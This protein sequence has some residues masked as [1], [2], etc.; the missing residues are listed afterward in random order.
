M[1]SIDTSRA[2]LGER[3][4]RALVDA[5]VA[6][7]DRL[8]HHY[9]ELKSE[10][11]LAGR[12][13]R[14]KIAKFILG[15][16][17]RMPDKAATAFEGYA[18]MVIGASSQ[19]LKGLPPV[20]V[21]DIEKGVLP[22]IGADGP[23]WDVARVPVPDSTNEVLLILV[24]PPQWGQPLFPCLKEGGE[25]NELRDGAIYYRASGQTREANSGEIQQ[26]LRRGQAAG[27]PDVNLGVAAQGSATRVDRAR[28]DVVLEDYLTKVANELE[29]A[30]VLAKR[31]AQT[32][33]DLSAHGVAA[34]YAVRNIGGVSDLFSSPE[35]RSESEYRA[36][37]SAW[38]EHTRASWPATVEQYLGRLLPVTELAVV[39]TEKVFLEDVQVKVHVAGDIVGIK[40]L[41]MVEEL[42]VDDLGLP[43]PPR[44]WGPTK[45]DLGW[46]SPKMWV[47]G[48]DYSNIARQITRR[49]S[50]DNSGSV[51]VAFEIGELRPLETEVTD[52]LDLVLITNDVQADSYDGTWT[53]TA[54]GHHAVFSGDLSMRVNDAVEA[55]ARLRRI[56]GL[57]A[58]RLS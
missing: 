26:L 54:R 35:G 49:A 11:D 56:L 18:V 21:L 28:L 15:S 5:V 3:R 25:R 46:E 32:P 23:R 58:E 2:P 50:W 53:V 8:E 33:K 27:V 29:L 51:R 31:P 24:D 48:A 47:S 13:D 39:N 22:Y 12:R 41:P 57:P 38:E 7:D 36:E 16:A 42:S 17:N 30:M 40:A 52:D 4:A 44:S 34:A 19:T 6:S 9:L 55:G 14:A 43:P 45:R 10:L 37:I 20:E 1:V